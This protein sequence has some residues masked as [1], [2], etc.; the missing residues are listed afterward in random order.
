MSIADAAAGTLKELYFALKVQND[1]RSERLRTSVLSP[2]ERERLE[3]ELRDFKALER[4]LWGL[5]DSLDR[6]RADV[7][8]EEREVG[9]LRRVRSPLRQAV[10]DMRARVDNPATRQQA[11]RALPGL[12]QQ[13]AFLE[14]GPAGD[15][16]VVNI[17]AWRPSGELADRLIAEGLRLDVRL[18]L[19]G[20][21]RRLREMKEHVR[22][23]EARLAELV[24]SLEGIRVGA[25]G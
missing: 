1:E 20:R 5:V 11:L 12:E 23:L 7:A 9:A 21:E 10:D 25:G 22:E 4:Q 17:A 13:L 18:N 24:A 2:A 3:L 8:P 14:Y 15:G 19:K 6:A 16:D